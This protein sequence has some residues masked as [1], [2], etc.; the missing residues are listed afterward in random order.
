MKGLVCG[1]GVLPFCLQNDSCVFV[2]YEYVCAEVV[3]TLCVWL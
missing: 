3:S 2:L 1:N